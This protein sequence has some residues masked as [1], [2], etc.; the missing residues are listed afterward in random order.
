MTRTLP[1]LSAEERTALDLS[2]TF[3]D[4]KEKAVDRFESAYLSALMR[5]CA[6]NLSLAAREADVARHYLRDRLKK[7]SLYGL[8]WDKADE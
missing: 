8:A 5:R 2:G 6:G 1:A 7:R 3:K 4:A